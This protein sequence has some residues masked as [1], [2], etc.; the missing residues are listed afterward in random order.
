[1]KRRLIFVLLAT[2]I[3]LLALGGW[4]VAALSTRKALTG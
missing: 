2:A 1:M 3:L 4:V